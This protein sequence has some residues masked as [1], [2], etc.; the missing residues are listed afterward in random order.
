MNYVM[1]NNPLCR[2]E[3]SKGYSFQSTKF[4]P[5][6]KALQNRAQK[7]NKFWQHIYL[8]LKERLESWL[9]FRISKKDG[10]RHFPL[11]LKT[12]KPERQFNCLN[13]KDLNSIFKATFKKKEKCKTMCG[14]LKEKG[15][16]RE[17]LWEVWLCWSRCGVVRRGVSLWG[18]ALRS[19]KCSNTTR[20][21]DHFPLPTKC[22]YLSRTSACTAP[23]P[24][25]IIM[26]WSSE[27]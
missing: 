15:P 26:D 22:S 4:Y 1:Q 21:S 14:G 2:Q 16:Q 12:S 17:Q 3:S 20:V 19:H 18:W 6:T 9:V 25:M 11:L 8:L 7:F 10:T 13:H 5:V 23:C 27:L 24:T